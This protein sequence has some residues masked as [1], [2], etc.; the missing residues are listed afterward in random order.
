MD[1]DAQNVVASVTEE[2]VPED[3]FG[4]ADTCANT[5]C[6]EP[7]PVTTALVPCTDLK[8]VAPVPSTTSLWIGPYLRTKSLTSTPSG[9]LQENVRLEV[10]AA[11]SSAARDVGAGSAGKRCPFS[12]LLRGEEKTRS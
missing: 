10:V 12:Q 7:R 5:S 9:G 6:P 8:T 4:P 1:E 3:F 2:N 11:L